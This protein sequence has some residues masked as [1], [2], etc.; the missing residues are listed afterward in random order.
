MFL[1]LMKLTYFSELQKLLWN[2]VSRF[3][4]SSFNTAQ[5]ERSLFGV[6]LNRPRDLVG[7]RG[8]HINNIYIT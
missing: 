2:V 3:G 8:Q 4:Y 1:P 7:S 5:L 6:E